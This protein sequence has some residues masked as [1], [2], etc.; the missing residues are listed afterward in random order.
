M[1]KLLS[2][3][4]LSL[5]MLSSDA[6][7]HPKQCLTDSIALESALLKM[8]VEFASLGYFK[9]GIRDMKAAWKLLPQWLMDCVPFIIEPENSK[10]DFEELDIQ[11]EESIII[12]EGEKVIPMNLRINHVFE[13]CV[14]VLKYFINE[15]NKA[16]GYA[17]E[18]NFQGMVNTLTSLGSVGPQLASNCFL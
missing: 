13:N 16:A 12:V 2:V 11:E 5:L 8:A 9:Q 6:Y 14:Q 7:F 3:I 17:K 10:Y 15:I 18:R 4:L 1:V